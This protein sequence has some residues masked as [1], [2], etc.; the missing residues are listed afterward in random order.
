MRLGGTDDRAAQIES[1]GGR[2]RSG[3]S[4]P[5]DVGPSDGSRRFEA[6]PPI[7]AGKMG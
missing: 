2:W 7:F 5:G 1:Y 6:R 3:E 4:R